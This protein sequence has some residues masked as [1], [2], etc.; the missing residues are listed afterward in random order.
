MN[1]KRLDHLGIV[2]GIIKDLGLIEAIDQRLQKDELGQEKITPGEAVAGMILNGLGFSDKPLSL[3]PIFFETKALEI[4]FRP[5]VE[6]SDFNRHKLGK[7]LDR[8]Y[9]YGC[10]S[11][12]FE[13]ASVVCL[14]EKVDLRFNSLDTTTLSLTGEYLQDSDE[15]MIKIVHGY[16]KDVRPDLKQVV[17]ELMV[18]Q[19]GGVPLITQSWDGNSSDSKIF[20]KRAKALIDYFKKSDSPRYLIADSKLYSRE[21]AENLQ[22]LKFITRIPGTNREE[23]QV[24]LSA[25]SDGKWNEL[26][27][28]NKYTSRSIVHH[29]IAQRWIIVFSEQAR[30]RISKT[31]PKHIKKEREKVEKSLWHLSNQAFHCASDAE[32]AALKMERQCRYHRI[33]ILGIEEKRHHAETGRPKK[34]SA[35]IKISYFVKASLLEDKSAIGAHLDEKSC[36]V[37]GT[38][39]PEAELSDVEVI[40]GY[41]RQNNSVENMGFRFLKDPIFFTS[42]LFLKKA[43]RIQGLLMVMTLALLVYSIAQRRIRQALKDKD[44]TLPNQIDKPTKTPTMRWL[45]QLMEGL[46]FVVMNVNKVAT[47][48]IHGWTDIKKKIVML[49]GDTIMRI[50]QVTENLNFG[51]GG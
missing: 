2:A 26:D 9:G 40:N 16:S 7:I 42:S 34:D 41:K 44:E 10:E 12:F 32:K 36:Y 8:A 3:T 48:M 6:A 43:S 25:I 38:N 20:D 24:I 11:L 22:H 15:N 13:I 35:P 45:F 37:L 5:G 31:L 18:S 4:L 23:S 47:R 21:N 1:I 14:Q 49:M 19:D 28:K 30:E 51:S 50:Y 39:I 17:Q 33:H 29:G 46:H 27:K